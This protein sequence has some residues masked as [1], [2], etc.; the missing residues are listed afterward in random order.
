MQK[1]IR[2][3]S[4]FTHTHTHNRFASFKVSQVNNKRKLFHEH[5][6]NGYPSSGASF[7]FSSNNKSNFAQCYFNASL[8]FQL[9]SDL[10]RALCVCVWMCINM[11]LFLFIISGLKI[12][13]MSSRCCFPVIDSTQ[14][15]R[16]EHFDASTESIE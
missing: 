10:I 11:Q 1:Y 9:H 4:S 16:F 14:S 3:Y 15:N 6:K 2:P 12:D 13:C 8:I 5:C 7:N